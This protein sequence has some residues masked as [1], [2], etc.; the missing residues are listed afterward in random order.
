MSIKISVY[1]ADDFLYR[2]IELDA[3]LG[4]EL[5]RGSE[6]ADILLV[7]TDTASAPSREHITMSR[8]GS[9]ELDIPFRLGSIRRIIEVHEGGGAAL[10]LNKR[11]R[12]ALLHGEK[13][14]LTEVELSLLSALYEKGG[15]FASREEL[16]EAVWGAEAQA[17]ILN[18]YIHYLREKLEGRG[19]KIII[20][21]RRCGYKIDKRY[22]GGEAVCSE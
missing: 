4:T 8:R 17:G 22:L 3:P 2:K 6:D 21:S 13:I 1:T 14:R 5:A 18:V 20:S 10:S 16:L 15:E 12:Y 11:E 7:D 19:E 9:S